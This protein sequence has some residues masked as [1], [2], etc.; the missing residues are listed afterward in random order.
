M[1]RNPIVLPDV[2][3]D[4]FGER[5]A[6]LVRRRAAILGARFTFESAS[7]ELMRLVDLAYAGLPRHR[8]TARPPRLRV[9]LL[10]GPE[11]RVRRRRCEPPSLDMVSG[12]G[13]LGGATAGSNFVMVSA[14]ARAA[15]VAVSASMLRFP[16]HTR[17][18]LIEFA[19]F[20]LAARAQG[21][22]SLHAACIA[23]A[24]RGI[25][26]MGAS[27]SG[28]STITLQCLKAGFEMV[29]E[30][31]VFVAPRS[32]LA[33]GVANFLHVKSDSLR[34]LDRAQ[35]AAAMRQS[36]VIRRR[37]GVAKY[38]IDLRGGG[39]RLAAAPPKVAAIVFL[40]PRPSVRDSLLERL[41]RQDLRSRLTAHQAYAA[42]QPVWSAFC[43][44]AARIPAYELCR[45]RHPLE[46]VEPLRA[47][48]TSRGWHGTR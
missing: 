31:S 43:R 13:H 38:E 44:H 16:Y 14:E 5:S 26:L 29:S 9:G 47:L 48:L 39:F 4:P 3:E 45:G 19:V 15:V 30:D 42:H 36:A 27:G 25:L 11:A 2:L 6:T 20:T 40:S 41:S 22:V 24:G 21:L 23:A 46:A 37:S 1:S 7:P 10:L 33:T 34:W 8:L 35:D 12:A 17:Y 18:E 32:M 28:K